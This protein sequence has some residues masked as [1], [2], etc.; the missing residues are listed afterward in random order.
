MDRQ[1]R[2]RAQWH[3]PESR[4]GREFS[5][6]DVYKLIEAMA[7]EVGRT[8]DEALEAEIERLGA[9]IEA[10][11]EDDGYLNTRFDHPGLDPRY[12]DFEWATSSTA[13]AT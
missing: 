12:T 1:L 10:V 6:S 11:Q 5:D 3:A 8:G 2:P 4:R 13:T 9:L 7:W